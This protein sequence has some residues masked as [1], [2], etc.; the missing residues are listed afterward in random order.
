MELCWILTRD[1]V[2]ITKISFVTILPVLTF[3]SIYLTMHSKRIFIYSLVL[4]L[5]LTLFFVTDGF[6]AVD[7][8]YAIGLNTQG[9]LG[10]AEYFRRLVFIGEYIL[11]ITVLFTAVNIRRPYGPIILIILWIF[12]SVDLITHQVYGRPADVSNIAMLNASVANL[13]DALAQY[14]GIILT[15]LTKTTVIFLPLIII[16][17]LNLSYGIWQK[18]SNLFFFASFVCL[19][20]F[21]IFILVN[22]GAPALIGF[23]KG[24]SYGFGSLMIKINSEFTPVQTID[25]VPTTLLSKVQNGITNIIVV[26]DES[27]E[28][29]HFSQEFKN[30][31]TSIVNFGIAFSGGNCSATSN[32]IIRK[33]YWE[34]SQENSLEIKQVESLFSIAN[35]HGFYTTY[36]DNQSV[37]RD[38]TIRNYIDEAELGQIANPI[39][40]DAPPH[41]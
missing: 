6:Y 19:L 3:E 7:R 10:L 24:F 27:I 32:Y 39:H 11:A 17:S 37:L 16:S 13:S 31:D 28:Y 14:K 29:S 20:F 9:N 34:R 40:N 41:A 33:G 23:P 4:L 38:K 18:V 5:S 12:F 26:V 22:R 30:S 2:C 25:T 21:Y 15:A 36:I 8:F 35:R 1:F